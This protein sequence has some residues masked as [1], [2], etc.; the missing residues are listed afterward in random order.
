[1]MEAVS[2]E[3]DAHLNVITTMVDE[4]RTLKIGEVPLM[5]GIETIQMA[6]CTAIIKS[7]VPT[8]TDNSVHTTGTLMPETITMKWPRRWG[9]VRSENGTTIE[10]V[11]PIENGSRVTTKEATMT[12]RTTVGDDYINVILTTRESGLIEP[13]VDGTWL[14]ITTMGIAETLITIRSRIVRKAKVL[15]LAML[16]TYEAPNEPATAWSSMAKHL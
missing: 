6:V 3:V 14:E 15:T 10:A 11:Y 8:I 7:S 16:E 2:M 1:M 13:T 9:V 4:D 5:T 12:M